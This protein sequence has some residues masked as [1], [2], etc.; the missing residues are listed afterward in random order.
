VSGP[1][2]GESRQSLPG[3]LALSIASLAIFLLLSELLLTFWNPRAG[4]QHGLADPH[5]GFR[6]K[7]NHAYVEV[8]GA[9]VRTNAHGF[10]DA[11][12]RISRPPGGIRILALGDSSTFGYGVSPEETYPR[13]LAR[14]LEKR[15]PGRPIEVLNAGTPGW[16]AA[17]G[18]AWLAREGLA[19]RPDVVIVSFGYNEQLGSGEGATH[20]DYDPAVRSVRVHG[21]GE[22]FARLPPGAVAEPPPP[23]RGLRDRLRRFP[24]QLRLY[25]FTQEV[26]RRG[27]D[28]LDRATGALKSSD[29]A[30]R[31]LGGI[32]RRDPERVRRLLAVPV[33]GNHVV[34]SY[35]ASLGAIVEMTRAAGAR[36]VIVLQP[37]RAY[38]EFLDWLPPGPRAANLEAV[39]LLRTGDA[40]RALARLGA[41]HRDRPGDLITAFNLAAALRET[42]DDA[43][44]D[45][46]L[47]EIAGVRTFTLNAV[48]DREAARLRVP[49]VHAPLA[50]EASG[51]PDLFFPDRYHTRPAGYAIVAREIARALV[52]HGLVP[53]GGPGAV[54]TGGAGAGQ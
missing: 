16:S 32:Y 53:P 48:A 38:R 28:A 15:F 50:F 49:V 54:G 22:P 29:L 40:G 9:R 27:R 35:A 31:V 42:R 3:N 11:P 4:A 37:R 44:A 23:G 2:R 20:Y 43:G 18:A 26:I 17:N 25:R 19:L 21:L 10:R 51:A 34:D 45:R 14:L 52:E 41:L 46:A 13:L 8:G 36:P 39:N 47:A 5:V 1:E 33:R 6:L 30:V 24:T 12:F 7:P